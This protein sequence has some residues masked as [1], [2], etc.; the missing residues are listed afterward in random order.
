[1][2]KDLKSAD[3]KDRAMIDRKVVVLADRKDTQRA[4]W[5]DRKSGNCLVV[6]KGKKLAEK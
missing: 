3:W 1:M 5:L 2:L 6:M 4:D